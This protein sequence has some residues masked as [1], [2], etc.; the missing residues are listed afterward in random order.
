MHTF[1]V[2]SAT[3]AESGVCSKFKIVPTV[4]RSN[5]LLCIT[6]RFFTVDDENGAEHLLKTIAIPA[7]S[8]LCVGGCDIN[9]LDFEILGDP[10]GPGSTSASG[11]SSSASSGSSS[12]NEEEKKVGKEE[13]KVS[14]ELKS[15]VPEEK[16]IALPKI[17]PTET[18]DLRSSELSETPPR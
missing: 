10:R 17:P 11:T 18:G 5:G 9:K 12:Q 1:T 2:F 7:G 15:E 16:S 3:P 6:L 14:K 4:S 13:K 8:A